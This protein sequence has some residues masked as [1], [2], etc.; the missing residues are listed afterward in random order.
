MQTCVLLGHLGF[1]WW[2][3]C[4]PVFQW[5]CLPL[6]FPGVRIRCLC[7]VLSSNSSLVLSVF[8]FFFFFFF[9]PCVD[10]FMG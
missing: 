6:A 1:S 10:S 2:F 7:R 3:S 8:F 5:C 9:V 4:A